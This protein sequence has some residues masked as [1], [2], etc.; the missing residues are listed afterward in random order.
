MKKLLALVVVTAVGAAAVPALAATKTVR[1]DDN[2]FSPKSV[3][4]S[5]G[6][7]LT[8]RWVGDAPHNVKGAGI[9]IGNRTSGSRTVRAKR[10]GTLVCTIHP[11][12]TLKLRVR[13]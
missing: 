13:R 12:M 8:F 5:K 11:G 9:N 7:K 1:V 3:T 10:S 2:V 6:A 4:V